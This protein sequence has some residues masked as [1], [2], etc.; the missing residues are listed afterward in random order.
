MQYLNFLQM[1]LVEVKLLLPVL[2]AQR[3]TAA[4]GKNIP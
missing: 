2:Q 4:E 3:G 1:G